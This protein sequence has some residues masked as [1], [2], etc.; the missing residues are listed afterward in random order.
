[1]VLDTTK[2]DDGMSTGIPK[3]KRITEIFLFISPFRGN[4]LNQSI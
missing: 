1:V 4:D 2:N 3:L